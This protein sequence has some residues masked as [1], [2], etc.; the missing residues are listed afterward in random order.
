MIDV[1]PRIITMGDDSFSEY[2]GAFVENFVATELARNS[3][4][5][6]HYWISEGIAEIDF[7]V[8]HEN[9]V[10]PLEVK[11][12]LNRDQE[13]LGLCRQ[14]QA[15]QSVPRLAEKLRMPRQLPE[16]PPLCSRP[17]SAV[18]VRRQGQ[19]WCLAKNRRAFTRADF[20][21]E[22]KPVRS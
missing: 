17:F 15:L 2:N 6:L 7:L 19:Y 9:E 5:A 20:H 18:A 22:I 4:G 16:H 8:T 14:I 21:C 3:A 1:P 10:R 13:S 11:S 12:G